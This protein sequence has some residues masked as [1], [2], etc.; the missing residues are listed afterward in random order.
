MSNLAPKRDRMTTLT[1]RQLAALSILHR[2]G[3]IHR[4]SP[5]FAPKTLDALIS[6]GVA[7]PA[8]LDGRQVFP[9]DTR[10][11]ADGFGTWHVSVPDTIDNGAA[12]ARAI[13]AGEVWARESQA[14]IDNWHP[15]VALD[16]VSAAGGGF[17]IYREA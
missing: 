17:A 7:A 13:I 5:G 15:R 6:A 1:R 12:V 11:W 14:Y 16:T 3:V 10:T 8:G 4:G 9:L 2:Q